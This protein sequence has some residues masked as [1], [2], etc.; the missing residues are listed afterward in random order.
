MD[1]EVRTID[2]IRP[3]GGNRKGV[4]RWTNLTAACSVCNVLKGERSV[5]DFIAVPDVQNRRVV[6]AMRGKRPWPMSK[7]IAFSRLARVWAAYSDVWAR[8]V[9]ERRFV[10]RVPGLP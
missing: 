8:V 10:R 5:L 1:G 4:G 9:G 7:S 6:L 2:H 3:V